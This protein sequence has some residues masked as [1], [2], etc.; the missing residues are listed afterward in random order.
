MTREY[1]ENK[2][3]NISAYFH[4]W[5]PPKK[6]IDLPLT[7][8]I[9]LAV[10]VFAKGSGNRGSILGRLIPKTHKWYLPPCLKLSIIRYGSRVKWSNPGK[11]VAPFPTLQWS[12]Y[13]KGSLRVP[14]NYSRQLYF[15]FYIHNVLIFWNQMIFHVDS[16]CKLLTK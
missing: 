3:E 15:Y 13:L 6:N 5:Y 2:N 10:R 7:M 14:L 11:E 9:G 12:S 8:T 1:C 4:S 16:L